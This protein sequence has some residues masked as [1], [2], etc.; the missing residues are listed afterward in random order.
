MKKTLLIVFTTL[1]FS[2][3]K[4][5]MYLIDKI[6]LPATNEVFGFYTDINVEENDCIYFDL[7]TPDPEQKA[8]AKL[9]SYDV[10]AFLSALKKATSIFV[11]WAQIAKK[12]NCKLLSKQIP[13][14]FNDLTI[15]FF[16]N[17]KWFFE[18]GVDMRSLFFVDDI[19][20]CHFILQSDYMTS[21]ETIAETSSRI[22]TFTTTLLGGYSNSQLSLAR[23]CSGS[24]LTFNSKDEIDEFINKINA[25]IDWKEQNINNGKLFK[26]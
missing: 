9:S 1:L 2:Q 8:R 14:S 4:A 11:E 25:T 26:K 17:N 18:E 15:F 12:N 23:Y 22:L 16:Q 5:Q 19:G 6:S 7:Q 21:Q 24:S 20:N 13:V 3:A 10:N